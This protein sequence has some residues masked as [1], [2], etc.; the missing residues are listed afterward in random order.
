MVPGR[1]GKRQGLLPGRLTFLSGG[2]AVG[3]G[4]ISPLLS[5]AMFL[6]S[7]DLKKMVKIGFKMGQYWVETG[8]NWVDFFEWGTGSRRWS[9]LSPPI[10]C[11]VF[12]IF[13]LEKNW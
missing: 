7:F 4:Q 6:T 8:K 5:P 12:D 10:T 13:R 9:H 3:D 11:D 1:Q 2:R